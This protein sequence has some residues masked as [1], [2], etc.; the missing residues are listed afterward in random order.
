MQWDADTEAEFLDRLDTAN[1][2]KEERFNKIVQDMTYSFQPTITSIKKKKT[3][4]DEEEDMDDDEKKKDPA[5]AFMERLDNDIESY[6]KVHPPSTKRRDR[7]N[8]NMTE[9]ARF[10]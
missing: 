9:K 1:K 8:S 3:D 4:E 6:R 10:R 7:K 2:K 5:S